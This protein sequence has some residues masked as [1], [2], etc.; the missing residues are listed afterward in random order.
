MAEGL[1]S[2][3]VPMLAVLVVKRRKKRGE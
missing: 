2:D 1:P 3:D